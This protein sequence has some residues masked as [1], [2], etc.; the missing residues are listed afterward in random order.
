MNTLSLTVL[1][2]ACELV[3]QT[4]GKNSTISAMGVSGDMMDKLMDNRPWLA[5]DRIVVQRGITALRDGMAATIGFP[6]FKVPAEYQ[7]AIINHFVD[8]VNLQIACT[9][10]AHSSYPAS[11]MALGSEASTDPVSAHQLFA[12]ILQCRSGLSEFEAIIDS[13]LKKALDVSSRAVGKKGES[14][15][16]S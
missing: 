12:L 5:G 6:P 15:N 8:P 11:D 14:V 3:K 7:A 16:A 9:W 13:K 1:N 2:G 4:L 10:C